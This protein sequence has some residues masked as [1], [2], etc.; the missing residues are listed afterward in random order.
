MHHRRRPS[1]VSS[2]VPVPRS[3][4]R[5]VVKTLPRR[6]S[7]GVVV[8]ASIFT[9]SATTALGRSGLQPR[10]QFGDRLAARWR[11]LGLGVR[12]G[13]AM[14]GVGRGGAGGGAITGSLSSDDGA[15]GGGGGGGGDIAGAG[16]ADPLKPGSGKS[17]E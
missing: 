13:A 9:A 1:Q 5:T 14:T 15:D 17:A 8:F 10:K 4:Y 12:V 3:G 2:F 16:V 11:L 6:R 7:Y